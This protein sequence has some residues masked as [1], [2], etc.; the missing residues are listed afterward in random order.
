MKKISFRTLLV[1]LP[2]IVIICIPLIG[3]AQGSNYSQNTGSN[4]TQ[5]SNKLENPLNNINNFCDLVKVILD[6]VI[7]IGMPIAVLF[8]VYVGFGFI[9]ARGNPEKMKVARQNFLYTVIGIAIFL[10]AWTIAKII[11]SVI[12]GLGATGASQC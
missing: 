5:G 6:A 7:I 10:G 9:I 8:L 1:L 12:I 11:Q 3:L 2:T 4:Y